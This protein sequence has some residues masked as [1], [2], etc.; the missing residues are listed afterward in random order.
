MRHKVPSIVGSAI[1][2][3]LPLVASAAYVYPQL[4]GGQTGEATAPMKHADISFDGTNLSVH[5]DPTVPTPLLRPLTPPDEFNPSMPY[6]VLQDKAYNLQ[7]GWNPQRLL[8]AAGG[9]GGLGRAPL[10]FCGA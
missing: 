2:T 6:A 5:I 3:L 10:G 8:G 7:Y 9:Y 4:G 1:L